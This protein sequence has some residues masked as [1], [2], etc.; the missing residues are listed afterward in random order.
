MSFPVCQKHAAPI[1]SVRWSCLGQQQQ[2]SYEDDKRE[3]RNACMSFIRAPIHCVWLRRTGCADARECTA[4]GEAGQPVS[5]FGQLP[6]RASFLQSF[7]PI[8]LCHEEAKDWSLP[9]SESSARATKVVWRRKVEKGTER[10]GVAFGFERQWWRRCPLP[11][12]FNS[13]WTCLS[14]RSKALRVSE[15]PLQWEGK[16]DVA[17]EMERDKYKWRK[18]SKSQHLQWIK[19]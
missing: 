3:K 9:G 11:C 4:D 7:I 13:C 2:V 6:P 15:N 17:K 10:E 8:I 18:C 19:S 16:R 1:F 14:F 5:E 12:L